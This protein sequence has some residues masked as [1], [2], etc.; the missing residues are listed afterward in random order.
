M[1]KTWIKKRSLISSLFLYW[2]MLVLYLFIWGY[3]ILI[4]SSIIINLIFFIG[5][6]ILKAYLASFSSIRYSRLIN[7]NFIN[8]R[9]LH[10]KDKEKLNTIEDK[11]LIFPS[12]I[13]TWKLRRK[14]YT[15]I[16]IF[17]IFVYVY[18]P[19]KQVSSTDLWWDDRT[20]A[21]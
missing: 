11:N 4:S 1:D 21:Y 9:I 13:I 2:R 18:E 17:I 10:Y 16:Q 15:L 7:I 3:L 12:L 5:F 14:S 8:R 20:R 19:R 6:I